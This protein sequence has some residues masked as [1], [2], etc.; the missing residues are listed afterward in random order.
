MGGVVNFRDMD[1]SIISSEIA[2]EVL[3]SWIPKLSV[4]L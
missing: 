4:F 2:L 3:K 1:I